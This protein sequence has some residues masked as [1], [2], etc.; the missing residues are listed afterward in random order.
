MAIPGVDTFNPNFA[1]QQVQTGG[2]NDVDID[3]FL[4]IM[5]TELQ[6]Q[7]PLNP[8]ENDELIQQISQIRSVGATE[9][10]TQTLD[11]VLLGQNVSSATNLIGAE[12]DGLS[13]DNENVTGVVE[14]VSVANGTPKLHLDLT[15][16]VETL[17]DVG[18]VEAGEFEYRVVWA[19][20]N[21]PKKVFGVDPLAT[22]ESGTISTE[23]DGSA[24]KISNLPV[25]QTEKQIFRRKAG[26]KDF[27]LVGALSDG[28]SATFV[29]TVASDNLSTR[30]LD[31]TPQLMD[32]TRSFVVSLK[33]VGEIRPPRE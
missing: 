21:D 25:T 13:D 22:T 20:K 23:G 31:K 16:R 17:S 28:K 10:L 9:K 5:I 8:L 30:V 29:D 7:D 26:E 27:R 19:D 33:N 11:S 32:P 2:I 15:P 3:D 4:K 14:H 24:I 18:E 6:N 12:I 1:N